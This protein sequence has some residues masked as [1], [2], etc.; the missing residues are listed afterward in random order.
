M[1]KVKP[2]LF[3]NK[4]DR[5][6]FEMKLSGEEMYQEFQKVIDNVNQITNTYDSE[7]QYPWTTLLDPRVGNVAFGAGRDCWGFT[8]PQMAKIYAKK[9]KIDEIKLRELLWGD[10]FYDKKTSKWSKIK[11]K[12]NKRGFV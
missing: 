5:F 6:I 1:E 4:I 9:F 7:Q 3:I 2:V 12:T 10:N 8:I 11:T